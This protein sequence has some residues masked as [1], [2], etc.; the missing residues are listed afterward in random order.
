MLKAVQ[1][2]P[3]NQQSFQFNQFRYSSPIQ[4]LDARYVR[5]LPSAASVHQDLYG[6]LE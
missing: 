6:I 1:V 3:E 5:W 2:L 4:D